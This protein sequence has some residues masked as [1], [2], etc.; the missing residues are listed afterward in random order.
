MIVPLPVGVENPHK[1]SLCRQPRNVTQT[2]RHILEYVKINPP[3]H[4]AN[5]QVGSNISNGTIIMYS[6]F[7]NVFLEKSVN[8]G[9][10]QLSQ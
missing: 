6:G 1:F 8:C 9:I 10:F 3:Q 7:K 4:I 2:S 5:T